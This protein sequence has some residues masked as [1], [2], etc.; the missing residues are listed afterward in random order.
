[1]ENTK[2]IEFNNNMIKLL[3]HIKHK[4]YVSK[5]TRPF[6]TTMKFY[7]YLWMARD[8]GLVTCD[9]LENSNH[10]KRWVL[11]PKGKIVADHLLVVEKILE[12]KE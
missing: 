9:G 8:V 10:Q 2:N 1:M 5:G 7:N 12:G 6:M 11:S 3:L 4:G